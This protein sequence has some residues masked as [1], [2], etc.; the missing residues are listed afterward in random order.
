[1]AGACRPSSTP[2]HPLSL[3]WPGPPCFRPSVLLPI[4]PAALNRA[5]ADFF[6]QPIADYRIFL[7][8]NPYR[9]I[10]GSTL[11]QSFVAGWN[12]QTVDSV[13]RLESFIDHELIHEWVCLEGSYDETV[14]FNEGIADYYGIVL[15]HRHSLLTEA[16]YLSRVNLSA[17][18]CFASPYHGQPLSPGQRP[19]LDGLPRNR[20]PTAAACSTS[21]SSTPS[22]DNVVGRPAASTTWSGV[23]APS[24]LVSR[25]GGPPAWQSWVEDDSAPKPSPCLK[26]CCTDPRTTLRPG[27][28]L[29]LPVPRRR[30][31]SG[32][33]RLRRDDVRDR[34]GHQARPAGPAA[35]VEASRRV[36]P[37]AT[38]LRTTT[39]SNSPSTHPWR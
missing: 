11:R 4:T 26:A 32:R 12:E 18:Q 15:P 9:G 6:E 27:V 38:S 16:D 36:T 33:A 37:S 13:E 19:V 8:H 17:R 29:W 14:W 39:S 30:R 1:M 25:Q 23:S 28:G 34:H 22:C 3:H 5:L 20:S 7:R 2:E 21:R 31:R 24:Q 10:S 35:Q